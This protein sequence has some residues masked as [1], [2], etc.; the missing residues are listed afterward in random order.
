MD[1]PTERDTSGSTGWPFILL[2]TEEPDCECRVC[3]N[4]TDG[5]ARVL[6]A[7]LLAAADQVGADGVGADQVGGTDRPTTPDST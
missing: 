3:L 6:A 2:T 5:E 1:T 4:L 7:Q